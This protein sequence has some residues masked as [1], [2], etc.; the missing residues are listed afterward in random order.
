ME[1]RPGCCSVLTD[2]DEYAFGDE[3]WMGSRTASP[4]APLNIYEMHP[5]LME[6]EPG[7]RKRLVPL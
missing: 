4:D 3:K 6:A 1:L 5:R 7:R 2:P